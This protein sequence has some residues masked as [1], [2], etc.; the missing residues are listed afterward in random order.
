M[1][2]G[3]CSSVEMKLLSALNR[4]PENGSLWFMLALA[5]A[6]EKKTDLAIKA[7]ERA[8]PLFLQPAPVYFNLGLLSM[9]KNELSRAEEAY[10]RGLALCPS[11][12]QANKNYAFLLMQRGKLLD[13]TIPLRRLRDLMPNDLKVRATLIEIYLKVRMKREGDGDYL[14]SSRVVTLPPSLALFDLLQENSA[15]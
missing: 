11:N 8:L 7:L 6:R 5:R 9:K 10:A 12:V 14:M 3:Q 4:D 2:S 15:S 1:I 13:A